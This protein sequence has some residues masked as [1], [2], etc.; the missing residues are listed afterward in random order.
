MIEPKAFVEKAVAKLRSVEGRAVAA[1]SGGI[2]STTAA[3]LAYR[4]LRERLTP[5]MIDTGF[6]RKGEVNSVSTALRPLIPI[7]VIDARKDFISQLYGKSDAEEKRKT[8]RELF[9]RKLGEVVKEVGATHLV[10]GTIAAD[11]VETAGGIKTQ[12]NVLLQLGLDP[13]ELYG[14]SVVEPLVELYKDEVRAVARYLGVPE[15]LV[16]RQPFPGPGLLVRVLGTI[17]EEKLELCREANYLT[18]NYLA[19][20]NF[21][22]YFAVVFEAE[23]ELRDGVKFYRVRATGVKGDNRV[24]GKIVS[25]GWNHKD[26]ESVRQLVMKLSAG[27]VTHVMIKVAEGKGK[28][29][30][31]IRAVTTDDF[32]TADFAK[33]PEERLME[34][35]EALASIPQV[36]EVL[37]DVTSKPPATI[38]LE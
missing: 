10:Q 3:I 16:R 31:G 20:L 5:V 15:E 14:F 13:K 1:V 2:D 34:L 29:A 21:S 12:H 36:G 30:I 24:Y 37:Y 33:I 27:D 32:M 4:A 28:Y 6:M 9:Y 35:G 18:E 8:F 22:Q 19:D 26:L 17:S 38:E 25:I 23:G 11:W 7:R